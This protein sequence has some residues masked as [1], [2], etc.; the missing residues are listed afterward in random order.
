MAHRHASRFCCVSG[1]TECSPYISCTSTR[2][3]RWFNVGCNVDINDYG[4]HIDDAMW[5]SRNSVYVFLS[6]KKKSEHSLSNDES[7]FG[8]HILWALLERSCN[9][10]RLCIQTF[11]SFALPLDSCNPRN[12][13]I[14]ESDEL[15]V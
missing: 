1:R 8:F 5:S 14:A 9:F 2:S 15:L 11:W 7:I 4:P 12:D 6:K 13:W 3:A 10:S